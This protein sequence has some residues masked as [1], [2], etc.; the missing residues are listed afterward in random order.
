MISNISCKLPKA[1]LSYHTLTL[2][3]PTIDFS[4]RSKSFRTP[5]AKKSPSNVQ[6]SPT[7]ARVLYVEDNEIV[8]KAYQYFL[9]KMGYEVDVVGNGKEL[10]EK[11][12]ANQYD[13][14]I[15]DGG[16]PDTTGFELGKY[17]R[18]DE[19]QNHKPRMPLLLLS[20]YPEEDVAVECKA[21]DIDAFLTKPIEYQTFQQQ[22][23]Y[24]LEKSVAEPA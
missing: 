13:L 14:I 12:H 15:L 8:R 5:K 18:E 16:L 17:I 2:V 23:K 7:T 11:Y 6:V 21:V 1:S 10:I 24:W 19:K 9:R 20:A 3:Q 22:V 4:S